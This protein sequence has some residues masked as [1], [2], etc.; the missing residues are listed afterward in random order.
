M[1][2]TNRQSKLWCNGSLASCLLP[3][4]FMAAAACDEPYED[5]L[6][7]PPILIRNVVPRDSTVVSDQGGWPFRIDL[8]SPI[9]EGELGLR[10][11]PAPDSVSPPVLSPG[12]RTLSYANVDLTD[13]D[14]KHKFLIDG[15]RFER[16]R[17]LEYLTGTPPTAS[18]AGY[19]STLNA[20][21]ARVDLCIVFAY[22]ETA[23]LDPYAPES[24]LLYEP[25]TIAKMPPRPADQ[26]ESAFAIGSLVT[27]GRYYIVAINDTND[28]GEYDPNLDWW[29][30]H[31]LV[32][33][34]GFAPLI[35]GA[36]VHPVGDITLRPPGPIGPR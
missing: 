36:F 26:T 32:G 35:A 6:K 16:P 24:L 22:L 8:R 28:D 18:V 14:I 3:L 31:R 20:A 19:I 27:D 10:I 9:Q 12:G 5:I 25:V 1:S 21:V 29:G 13:G 15:P 7:L 34:V 4:I 17:V 11:F 2:T 33:D 30:Y 23:N